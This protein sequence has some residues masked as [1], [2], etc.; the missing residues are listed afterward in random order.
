VE[1]HTKAA[2]QAEAAKKN[3][4]PSHQEKKTQIRSEWEGTANR[5]GNA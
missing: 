5:I 2:C 4:E 1:S 3:I